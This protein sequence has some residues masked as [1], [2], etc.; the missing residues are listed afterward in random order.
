M[1]IKR[2]LGAT[3]I[4]AALCAALAAPAAALGE[5]PDSDHG[6]MPAA[7]LGAIVG[8]TFFVVSVPFTSLIAP[9]H[10]L[11]SFDT[12]VMGPWRATT[13]EYRHRPEEI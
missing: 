5:E 2:T 7:F 12:L 13:G 1:R 4:S 10:M 3:A 8:A 9:K 11:Q 6:P